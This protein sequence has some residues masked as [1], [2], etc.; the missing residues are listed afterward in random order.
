MAKTYKEKND[1]DLDKELVEKREEL[2][3][4]RFG[5]AGSRTRDVKA[6]K[7]LR[8]EIA[9]ILTEKSSRK[10]AVEVKEA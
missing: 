1:K 8:K 4:F 2:R 10:E 7:N 5:V 3:A 6:G 9:R